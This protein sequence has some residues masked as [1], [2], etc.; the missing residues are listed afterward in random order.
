[1]NEDISFVRDGRRAAVWI[2][3]R[4]FKTQ[5]YADILLDHVLEKISLSSKERALAT[6]LVYGTLRWLGYIEWILKK[7]YRGL[8]KS[9]PPLIQRNLEVA[10]YQILFLSKIPE[11]AVVDEAVEIAKQTHGD[12]WPGRVNAVLRKLLQKKEN[13]ESL[14]PDQKNLFQR[15]AVECSHPQWLVERW[16]QR[17]GVDRTMALCKANNQKPYIGIRVN[18]RKTTRESLLEEFLQMGI[19]VELDPFLPEFLR[20]RKSGDIAHLAPFQQ[21]KCTVQDPSAGLVAHLMDPQPGEWILDLTS[22]P[23][24]KATHLAELSGDQ[25]HI[26][27]VDKY[28]HRL[29]MV[30]ENAFRLGLSSI[31]CVVADGARKWKPTFDKVLVDAPCTGVGIFRRSPEL[32]WKK[33]TKEIPKICQVQSRLLESAAQALKPGGVLVYSTCSV[34]EEENE[35]RIEAFLSHHPEFQIES[36]AGKVPQEFISPQGWIQTWPDLH[37]LDGAFAVLLRKRGCVL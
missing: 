9:V 14:L 6:E 24:G 1:V 30:K 21:G 27:A 5:S 18:L 13:I 4:V 15:I 23:G 16:I 10:V 35:Q 29:R 3:H 8:W 11:Y 20:I 28:L 37:D 26:V 31:D 36:I 17:F 33:I 7:L 19:E 12:Q 2:L 34:L 22:A 32:K 25:V